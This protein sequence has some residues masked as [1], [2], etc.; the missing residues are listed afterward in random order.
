MENISYKKIDN[1][2]FKTIYFEK[3]INESIKSIGT[4]YMVT[5]LGITCIYF[6]NGEKIESNTMENIPN[7]AERLYESLLKIN[8]N[9]KDKKYL[10][11]AFRTIEGIYE[12]N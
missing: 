2:I 5:P 4:G 8:N 6:I 7:M 11:S 10:K 9:D 3:Y 12:D 1:S